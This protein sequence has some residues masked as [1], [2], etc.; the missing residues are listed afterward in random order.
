MTTSKKSAFVYHVG[1]ISHLRQ[2]LLRG[3]FAFLSCVLMTACATVTYDAQADRQL[4]ALTQ[5]INFQFITWENQLNAPRPTPVT[6]NAKFYDKVETNITTLEIRMEAAQTTATNKLAG[7]FQSLYKQVEVFR[8]FQLK[9]GPF[10]RKAD[11]PFFHAEQDLLNVQIAPILTF[12]L[13]IKPKQMGG[14][15]AAKTNSAAVITTKGRAA[16]IHATTILSRATLAN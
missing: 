4:T 6:Y 11:A 16:A 14:S 10:K 13:S 7:I 5:E 15:S 12:E 1:K 8:K 2:R 9:H 3:S